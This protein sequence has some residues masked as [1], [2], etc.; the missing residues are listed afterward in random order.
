MGERRP[1]GSRRRER[2]AG[3]QKKR[4]ARTESG[5]G[6]ART[7]P[8]WRRA[9]D[10]WGGL[11]VV[12]SL[13]IAVLVVG[14]LIALNRPRS[15]ADDRPYQPISREGIDGRRWGNP[16]APVKIL[17]FAD[18]QCPFCAVFARDTEPALA[19]E[20]IEAGTV[21]LSFRNYAFLG[22]E[23][24]R[25]A[26]AAECAADQGYFWDYHDLLFLRQGRENSGA[27]GDD[28]LHDFARE[29]HQAQPHFDVDAFAG[30]LSSGRKRAVVEQ[31]TREAMEAGIRQ[32]P[33]FVINGK[34]LTGA[35]AI[36]VFRQA[37][38]QALEAS[39]DG[40]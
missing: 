23:S 39:G 1:R 26:E 7:R 21:S 38:Q 28:R 11:P 19:A 35:H 14:A 12:G 3:A 4:D 40:R 24:I 15:A 13:L 8:R 2:V 36:E 6:R 10:P 5:A 34:L 27:F 37:I 29:L 31:A 9:V 32:T 22:P 33:S 25:A 20:F 17:E 30:C 16:D 18:F